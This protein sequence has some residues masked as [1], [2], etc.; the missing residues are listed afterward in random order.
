MGRDMTQEEL[1]KYRKLQDQ[2]H[3]DPQNMLDGD[4]EQLA[5]LRRKRFEGE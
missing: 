5:E 2:R 4:W 1:E 3:D